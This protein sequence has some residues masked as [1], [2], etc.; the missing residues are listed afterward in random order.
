[1]SELFANREGVFGAAVDER[2]L[3]KLGVPQ[4]STVKI[5]NATF[6][7]RAILRLEPDRVAGGGMFYAISK[8]ALNMAMRKAGA[9][10]ESRGIIVATIAPGIVLTDMLATNRPSL[11]PRSR[12]AEESV[13]GIAAVIES[14]DK[15]YDGRPRNYDGS[16]L[17]W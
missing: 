2:L 5:G 17:P 13:A 15:S 3:A 11:V 16:I 1:L 7:L 9:E 10:L 8:A 12:T 14:L 6:E 4:G